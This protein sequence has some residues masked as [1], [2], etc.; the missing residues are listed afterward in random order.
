LLVTNASN[1][2]TFSEGAAFLSIRIE[3]PQAAT[4][5][6]PRQARSRAT[7]DAIIEAGARI[8]SDDGW[9]GFTTNRVAERAGV[10]IGSLYQYFED[11]FSLVDAIRQTHLE[12]GMQAMRR[13]RAV[14]LTPHELAVRI[15]AARIEAHSIHPGLHPVLLQEIPTARARRNP[16]S[17]YEVAY[18]S[19]YAKIVAD[20][21]SRQGSPADAVAGRVLSD[22]VDG[23]IHNA[24][25]RSALD[26]ERM[27]EELIR[28]IALYLSP[29]TDLP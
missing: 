1:P 15:V 26:D 9:A 21:R 13:V 6:T 5:K 16:A 29:G 4:R 12:N 27:R 3:N 23:V 20:F 17:D 22:A 10:S 24:A 7:V 2:H 28:L 19:L 25:S 18:L 8:L 11:K 14:G